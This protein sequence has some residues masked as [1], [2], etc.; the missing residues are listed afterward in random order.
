M[1]RTPLATALNVY[2]MFNYVNHPCILIYP[3]D[4]SVNTRRTLHTR[5]RREFSTEN[6]SEA[7][8][9]FVLR[10]PS[11]CS[12]SSSSS[13][14]IPDPID[15]PGSHPRPRTGVSRPPFAPQP[16]RSGLVFT[17]QLIVSRPRTR[18]PLTVLCNSIRV[19]GRPLNPGRRRP[20]VSGCC[21]S[22]IYI[23]R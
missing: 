13:R 11:S 16:G 18:Q 10:P 17:A 23:K 20:A 4:N 2:T 7:G 19:N 15:P 5:R 9:S 14:S 6:S 22:T 1:S 21:S 3:P 8:P 12:C